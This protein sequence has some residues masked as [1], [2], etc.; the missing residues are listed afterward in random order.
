M[1]TVILGVIEL[2]AQP[3]LAKSFDLI[4]S[5]ALEST[6]TELYPTELHPTELHPTE[7]R[8]TESIKPEVWESFG[9]EAIT[10]QPSPL[11][12]SA[13]TSAFTSSTPTEI[14][15]AIATDRPDRTQQAQQLPRLTPPLV[16]PDLPD[17]PLP[18]LPP[19][20]ELLPPPP[21]PPTPPSPEVPATLFVRRFEVVGS[22]VFSEAE[23]AEVTAPFTN[24]E[25]TF[26]EL[27]Q[28]RSAVTQLYIDRGYI[29]SGALIP[30][31]TIEADVVKIQVIEGSLEAIN[32]TG[33]RRLRPGYVRSRL[34]LVG[35]TPINQ[36]RL[37]E[38]LQLLQLDP[39][40]QS[41]SADLQAGTQPGTSVLQVAVQ[42]ADSFNIQLEAN[43]N[44]SPSVGTF[45]RRIQFDQA[46]LLGFG[47]GLSVDYANTDGSNEVNLSYIFP[48]NPRNGTLQFSTGRANSEVIKPPFDRA[49]ITT[50]S[51]YY[52]FTYRQPIHQTPSEE[53]TLGI[54]ASRQES[55]TQVDGEG[56]PLSV[57]ADA[58]GETRVSALRFFQEWTERSSQ[59]VFAVR[60]Q[61][62]LG[63][64]WLDATVSDDTPDSRF[65]AWRGQGQWVRLFAPDLLLLVRTDMQL[66]DSPLVSLE[67]F[68]IGGFQTVRGYGQDE[69]LSNNGALFSTE[70]R[71]PILRVPEVE[72]V[73]Q[74]TPFIDFGTAWNNPDLDLDPST[75]VGI[76]FGLL[77]QQRDFSARLDWGIPLIPVAGD[78]LT[79]Q[80]NGIYFSL[81]YTPF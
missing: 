27:L 19:P 8:P 51:R 43:N 36:N 45:R 44:R 15:T 11:D 34:A 76:G 9:V 41:I 63:V 61:F 30:P 52:E 35:Q 7:L 39:L 2:V 21:T 25:L 42:E 17:Q 37:L 47:D 29:T 62:S 72:G 24:R 22:T 3:V 46:N 59:H 81:I 58:D 31:Q 66:A 80:E 33:L 20:E 70:L 40:I 57:D 28:A 26:A 10:L 50:P 16:E 13:F 68:G 1:P 49:N 23:L 73:L 4:K 74:M 60:S 75:L 12:P 77:W 55:Q 64:D 79:W 56:F 65:L 14:A 6:P 71:L 18:Q 5:V 38:G 54:T 78:N 67:Q 69:I 48:I 32:V 53:F